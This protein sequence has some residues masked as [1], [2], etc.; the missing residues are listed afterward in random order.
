M[1]SPYKRVLI[2]D[3][4]EQAVYVMGKGLRKLGPLYEI[5]TTTNGQ[6]ALEKFKEAP[7][8]LLITDLMMPG[9]D[10]V[11]LT[12]EVRAL[13]PDV[14]V[15]WFSAYAHFDA[16]AKRLGVK[17]YMLKPFDINEIRQIA[18]DE[19]ATQVV[20]PASQRQHQEKSVLILDDND[21][22]R[23][24]FHRALSEAGYK[25]FPVANLQ[26]AR[27][28]LAHYDFD[29]FLC[30]IHL[31]EGRGTDLLREQLATLNQAETQ[32]IIVSA[33]PR[34]RDT[35]AEMGIEF[36]LEKPVAIPPLI[37]LVHRLMM[38][39]YAKVPAIEGT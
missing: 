10:G 23:R 11:Q 39:R 4:E 38:N 1:M 21:Y 20:R 14:P 17:H 8:D 37:T 12:E 18:Q 3:D 19:L 15:I 25:T 13:N 35:C 6:E 5:V 16:E 9:I 26:E 34:Y 29:V 36:Y 32:V 24:L 28:L 7:F 30:D 33:D 22:L 31:D 2:V 27:T